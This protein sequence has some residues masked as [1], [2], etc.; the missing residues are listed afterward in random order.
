M[1][2]TEPGSQLWWPA[3]IS[4]HTLGSYCGSS[5]IHNQDYRSVKV[6]DKL[7]PT[8][9]HSHSLHAFSIIPHNFRNLELDLTFSIFS[10][11]GKFSHAGPVG[12][13]FRFQ[14]LHNEKMCSVRLAAVSTDQFFT[15][16][17]IYL[18]PNTHPN[19][20][21]NPKPHP[22]PKNLTQT[23]KPNPKTKK[24]LKLCGISE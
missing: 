18:N 21:H 2:Y 14:R 17:A 22:N 11:Y 24:M 7:P 5:V 19:F 3:N 4:G 16:A 13:R 15:I 20:N 6:L 8:H 9:A 23:R 1:F 12:I 10:H